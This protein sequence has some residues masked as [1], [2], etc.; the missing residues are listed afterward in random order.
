M[1]TEIDFSDIID[2]FVQVQVRIVSISEL[3]APANSRTTCKNDITGLS[4]FNVDY[5]RP[6]V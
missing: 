4:F 5:S 1:E 2:T 3:S 6:T